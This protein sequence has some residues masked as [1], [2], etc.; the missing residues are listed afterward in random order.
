M[1]P[2]MNNRFSNVIGAKVRCTRDDFK[3]PTDGPDE[4]MPKAG[5]TY[6]VRNAFTMYG[7]DFYRFEEI[8]NPKWS[9]SI[10]PFEPAYTTKKF[11]IIEGDGE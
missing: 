1:Y 2:Q 5:E 4:E 9:T 3:G 10:G 8:K 7:E 6:T 11:E